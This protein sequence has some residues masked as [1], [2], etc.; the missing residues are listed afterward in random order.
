MWEQLFTIIIKMKV[1]F[2]ISITLA[3][4]LFGCKDDAPNEKPKLDFSFSISA[5]IVEIKGSAIDKDGKISMLEISWGDSFT[6]K[7]YQGDFSA[8]T[9]SHHYSAPGSYKITITAVDDSGESNIQDFSV[10]INYAT[11]SLDGIK[12][13]IF[14]SSGK[15]FLILTTNLHTYQEANQKEKLN[16]IID[17]IGM[18]DIDFILFQ[19]CAQNKSSQIVDGIIRND[20]M[21]LLISKGVAEKYGV[22]YNYIWDWSHYGWDVWEEGVAVLSKHSLVDNASRYI[23]TS[24][25]TSSITSRKVLYGSYAV[26]SLGRV[27]IFSAHTHWR[28]SV[29]DEEQNNQIKNIKLMVVE[30]EQPIIDNKVISF[31]GGDFNGNPTSDYPWSEGYN[32]MMLNNN[33]L[34]TFLEIYPDANSK[35][36]Q[37]IYNTIGGDLPGR[38]DYIF[39]KA[40][41][42]LKVM[43]SQIIFT[44]QIIGRV[45]DHFGVLTKVK[46]I[47]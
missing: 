19:E 38:I 14:K 47:E 28:T 25:S 6:D 9:K 20:N 44:E 21:A 41:P 39:M 7:L 11:T 40:N 24:N 12:Q 18:M 46:Y 2:I 32:T 42:Y 5:L 37:S 8:I 3:L 23:S 36:A 15:E 1:N 33:Y 31:V 34:D 10:V 45:S 26:L 16:L 35:P 22:T 17:V 43:D 29:N 13:S 27:N 4:S 30:K